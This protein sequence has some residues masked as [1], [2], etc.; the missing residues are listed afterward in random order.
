MKVVEF[1]ILEC[2]TF[3]GFDDKLCAFDDPF[4]YHVESFYF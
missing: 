4:K 1:T 2:T 3:F